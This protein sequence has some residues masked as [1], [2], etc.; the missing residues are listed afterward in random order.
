MDISNIT[1]IINTFRAET[2]KNSVTPETVGA[3]MQGLA[4]LLANAEDAAQIAA[5]LS[6]Y[7]K[8]AEFDE[9]LG[10]TKTI[11]LTEGGM[12]AKSG[13]WESK[14]VSTVHCTGYVDV[15]SYTK[16]TAVTSIGSS[17]YAVALFDASKNLLNDISIGGGGG[18][19]TYEIDLTAAAYAK[20]AYAFV[21]AYDSNADFSA[22][23]LTCEATG[24]I[25]KQLAAIDERLDEAENDISGIGAQIDGIGSTVASLDIKIGSEGGERKAELT[26][27][28]FY[29]NTGAYVSTSNA[30]NTGLVSIDGYRVVKYKS[31]IGTNAAL[32]AFYDAS[33][34][35]IPSLVVEGG[36]QAEG[37]IVLDASYAS[38]KYVRMCC[39]GEQYIATAYLILTN[40]TSTS[41]IPRLAAAENKI[42]VLQ[43][44]DGSIRMTQADFVNDGYISIVGAIRAS[45]TYKCT[46]FHELK[47]ASSISLLGVS[48]GES[49]VILCFYDTKKRK[50]GDTYNSINARANAYTVDTIPSGAVYFRC[51]T[52]NSA[53]SASTL[54]QYS[55]MA[56]RVASIEGTMEKWDGLDK[57]C[58]NPK[59]TRPKVLIFG[60]SISDSAH[61]KFNKSKQTTEYWFTDPSNSYTNSQGVR[62]TYYMWPYFVNKILNCSDCRCYAMSGASYRTIERTEGNERQN[63]QFQIDLA[64]NDLT[65]P[66]SVFPT[67][68]TYNP[69]IV[70][71]ALGIND[72]VPTTG[73]EYASTMAKTVFVDG[74]IDVDATIAAMDYTNR[75]D[76]V[77]GAFLRVKKAF[78]Y[79]LTFAVLPIQTNNRDVDGEV[80]MNELIRL[81]A[82][83]YSIHIIDG[84]R[85]MG[86]ARDFCADVDIYLKDG[87]HPNDKGQNLYTRLVLAAIREEYINLEAL[88]P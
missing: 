66:L 55:S 19:K 62:I 32:L 22:Y 68:G 7:L 53:L 63:L 28:G 64:M 61:I 8:K 39:Y 65:N 80:T 73:E 46:D 6:E 45:T 70:I 42:E 72:G 85:D 83:R 54:I 78:P 79:A 27:S 35:F 31:S 10:G 60:D 44:A 12:F 36:G 51:G 84:A 57:I 87:L 43:K 56:E 69:D 5:A 81:I 86:I 17:A 24:A 26:E 38:A 13:A 30:M 74:G 52:E 14:A 40:N 49:S 37:S 50:V 47:G 2:Q 34:N 82:Q 77:H 20:V 88:N 41:V 48:A 1:E 18:V 75:A 71:F 58:I 9:V 11:A 16:L 67:V 76:A 15:S 29:T 33:Q 3:I 4:E 23:S 21:S 25:N 59:T